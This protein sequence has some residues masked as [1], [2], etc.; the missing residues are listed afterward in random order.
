VK[1]AVVAQDWEAPM[2]RR[3]E[4]AP[5]WAVRYTSPPSGMTK[6]NEEEIICYVS[7]VHIERVQLNKC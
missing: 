4:E 6:Q 1:R 5:A 3:G 7:T 2:A